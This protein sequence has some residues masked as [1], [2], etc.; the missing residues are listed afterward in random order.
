MLPSLFQNDYPS[1]PHLHASVQPES[2]LST[3]WSKNIPGR[4]NFPSL[5]LP[6]SRRP[7]RSLSALTEHGSLN[8]EGTFLLDTVYALSILI[9]ESVEEV[10]NYESH[11]AQLEKVRMWSPAS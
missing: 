3:G 1:P 11:F 7:M 8:L 4:Q 2:M 9:F 6:K 5:L 10:T